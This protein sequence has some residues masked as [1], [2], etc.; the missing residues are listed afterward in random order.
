MSSDVW[1]IV[2]VTYL[3]LCKEA[4]TPTMASWRML[5]LAKSHIH[6]PATCNFT[7]NVEAKLLLCCHGWQ[8]LYCIMS[9][10]MGDDTRSN[11]LEVKF[12][13]PNCINCPRWKETKENHIKQQL[14]EIKVSY[15][16]TS[17]AKGSIFLPEGSMRSWETSLA[18]YIGIKLLSLIT[19]QCSKHN[20]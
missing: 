14:F 20:K 6:W 15:V 12:Q 1:P 5:A 11:L 17:E 7:R 18:W 2:E 19:A 8:I 16:E 13:F 10:S 3:M 9:E 4:D